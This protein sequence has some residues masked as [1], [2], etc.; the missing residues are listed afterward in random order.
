MAYCSSMECLERENMKIDISTPL[1]FYELL[2]ISL[3]AIAILIPIVQTIYRKWIIKP[4]LHFYPTGRAMVYFNQS[5]PYIRIDGVYEAENKPISIKNIEL[6]VT[7]KRDNQNLHLSWSIFISPI[8]QNLVG[9]F[10]QTTQAAHPFR[11]EEGNI[12][13][14]F[15][16]FCDPL[17]LFSKEFI[18]HT[19]SLFEKIPEI[20][21]RNQD[22]S[23]A[24]VEYTASEEYLNAERLLKKKFFWHAGEYDILIETTYGKEC[25]RFR[26]SITI[27]D[28]ESK[29]LMKNV[30]ESLVV[31]LKSA[32]RKNREFYT[33]IVK[34]HEVE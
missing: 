23:S 5:G 11:I 17:D 25:A 21:Q 32:Y 34:L 10:M 1:T 28:D 8:N 30:H 14:A 26:Y 4:K 33:E 15:T 6:T 24:L 27:G 20:I 18:K 22:Y 13:S 29:Q 19:S 2:A 3:A 7:R 16:E 12:S 9:T 31:P